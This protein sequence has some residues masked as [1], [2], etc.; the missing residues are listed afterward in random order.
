MSMQNERDAR[1]FLLAQL[2]TIAVFWGRAY[3][4]F[5]WD[6]PL[7]SL[8]WDEQLWSWVVEDLGGMAWEQYVVSPQIEQGILT[9]QLIFGVVYFLAGLVA[10]FI[11]QLRPAF[12]TLI[13]LGVISLICLSLLYWKSRFFKVGQF[14]E[15]SLQVGTPVLL[16]LMK[17]KEQAT[18]S[19]LFV[20]LI[21]T[22]FTFISHG[23]YAVGFYPRPGNFTSM[24]MAS[25]GFTDAT[26]N[27]LL[28][29]AGITD[30]VVASAIFFPG[31]VRKIGLVYCS[32][33]GF[34]TAFARIWAH[35]QW[36]FFAAGM[37]QWAYEF[38]VRAPHFLIPMGLLY[39]YGRQ[40]RRRIM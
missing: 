29:A 22:S 40:P 1:F 28:Y 38:I 6:V 16:I 30:F 10:L 2:A 35:V 33:W 19:I 21:L 31:L 36:D 20:F 17:R 4:H 3:Q 18:P 32:I 24:I 23:L 34:L 14:F 25:L 5:F 11:H 15:Y 13:W 9:T 26:A 7:R 8:F 39:W 12:R 27:I 37:H